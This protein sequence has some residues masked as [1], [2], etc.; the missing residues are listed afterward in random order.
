MYVP[1]NEPGIGPVAQAAFPSNR[2][3]IVVCEFAGPVNVNSYWDGGSKDE[4][5]LVNLETRQVWAVPTSHPFFDR[6]ESGERCGNLKLRELPP[7]TALV[8]GGTFCGKPATVRVMLR[9]ENL[10]KMLPA[11]NTLTADEKAALNV[12]GGM[13]GGYRA[14]EFTRRNLGEY[15]A[16]NPLVKSLA[17]KRLVTINRAGAIAITIEGRNAR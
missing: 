9:P 3:P 12:I 6:T 11:P 4:Y 2:K 1:I 16:D 15:G 17:D 7:N 13:K 5:R 8:T 10:V 14:D